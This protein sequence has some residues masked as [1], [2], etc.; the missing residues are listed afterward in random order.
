MNSFH[1]YREDPCE[2]AVPYRIEPAYCRLEEVEEKQPLLFSSPLP[3]RMLKYS[4]PQIAWDWVGQVVPMVAQ[5]NLPDSEATGWGHR[6]DHK[7]IH[8]PGLYVFWWVLVTCLH[9]SSVPIDRNTSCKELEPIRS[10]FYHA[11]T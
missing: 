5:V 3:D 7:A 6:V 10:C 4:C 1:A 8:S 9:L 11:V 2:G